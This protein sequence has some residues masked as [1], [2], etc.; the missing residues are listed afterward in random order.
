MKKLAA[1]FLALLIVG[2][3]ALDAE[4]KRGRRGCDDGWGRNGGFA[5]A[6]NW[7]RFDD[8][9]C[10][11]RNVNRRVFNPWMGRRDNGRHLGWHK[12]ARWCR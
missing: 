7:R 5:R 11:R 12:N 3:T 9:S 6:G 10:G 1:L 2:F 8:R 4:A